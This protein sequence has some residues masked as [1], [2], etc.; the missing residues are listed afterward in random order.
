MFLF[1]CNFVIVCQS[2]LFEKAIFRYSDNT[3]KQSYFYYNY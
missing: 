1:S 2:Q 3:S